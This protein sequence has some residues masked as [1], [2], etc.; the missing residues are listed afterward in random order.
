MYN[1]TGKSGYVAYPQNDTEQEV[2]NFYTQVV[3]SESQ[4][5]QEVKID[6]IR[7]GRSLTWE[8][9]KM[10]IQL[11]TEDEVYKALQGIGT[12]KA[13]GVDGY[14][15]LF[16]KS[17]WQIIKTDVM[18]ALKEFFEKGKLL[19]AMNCTL[20]TLIPKTMRARST[21]I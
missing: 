3:G 8:N 14:G 16:Y 2:V 20:V 11:V 10:L 19:P 7:K 1:L 9:A 18:A 13:P 6:A 21:R 12:D 5:T 17:S 4:V 15:S